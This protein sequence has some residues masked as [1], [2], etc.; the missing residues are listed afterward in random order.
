[1]QGES[2]RDDSRAPAGDLSRVTAAPEQLTAALG[3]RYRIRR[4]LGQG[5]MAVVYLADALKH[6]RPVAIKVLRPGVAR[7]MGAGR[8]LNEIRT[9]AGL[10]HPHILPLHDSGEA[11][12]LLFYVMPFVQGE[13]LRQRP[14]REG[15]LPLAEALHIAREVG[16]AL[17]YAHQRQVIHRDVKPE[18]ILLADG[19]AFVADFGIA[20][21]LRRA[22]D[23]RLTR[24][25]TALGTPAYMSPEQAFGEESVDARSDLYSLAC[26]V[27]EMLAGRNPWSGATV[28]AVLVSRFTGEPPRLSSLR[29]D[30]PGTLD[31]ALEKALARDP[32]ERFASV[33]G[34]L[35]SLARAG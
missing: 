29:P 30:L 5:G 14:P 19:H 8:F 1:M 10:A 28:E 13:S 26:V 3:G 31:D 21:A 9:T 17:E 16:D 32:A 27:Y 7:A 2:P 15:R 11:G 22:T 25:G 6:E 20:R 12:D 23:A 4:E 34:F 24:T 33:A 35:A 18:N